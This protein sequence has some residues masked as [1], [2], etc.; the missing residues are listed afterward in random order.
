MAVLTLRSLANGCRVAA[1]VTLF[2][3]GPLAA[4]GDPLKG[5]SQ[6]TL[7][8]LEPLQVGQA[9]LRRH[10]HIGI[11]LR[12]EDSDIS[13]QLPPGVAVSDNARAAAGLEA[14]S[15]R[16]PRYRLLR[17]P[18]GVLRLTPKMPGKCAAH[19]RKPVGAMNIDARLL[20]VLAAIIRQANPDIADVPA[21]LMGAA[22]EE[23]SRPFIQAVRYSFPGGTIDAALDALVLTA[24]GTGWVLIERP[25]APELDAYE[26]YCEVTI[27]SGTTVVTGFTF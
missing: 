12:A 15:A 19:L 16:H 6:E 1:I 20:D 7:L 25:P 9:F 17:T 2:W 4:Q 21:S 5:V 23:D 3:G 10:E 24:P 14:F 22:S 8:G 27:F 11:L 26:S 13:Y 18:G